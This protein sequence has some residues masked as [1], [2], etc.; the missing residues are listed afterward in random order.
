MAERRTT[1]GTVVVAITVVAF[2][3]VVAF[4]PSARLDAAGDAPD[5]ECVQCHV[6]TFDQG[7]AHRV[8]HTPFFERQC[9]AC[10]VPEG[11]VVYPQGRVAPVSPITGSLVSQEAMWAKRQVMVSAASRATDHRIIFDDLEPDATY[12]FRV[13]VSD[14]AWRDARGGA[15]SQ[16]LGLRLAEVPDGDANSLVIPLPGIA[17]AGEVS[18]A[19]TLSR[20]GESTLLIR[21]QTDRPLFGWLELETME[22]IFPQGGAGSE[23]VATAET[24]PPLR[25]PEEAAIDVCYSCHPAPSIG[26]SHPVRVYAQGGEIR[27]PDDLPTV[28]DGMITC[29]TCHD[30]H[31]ADGKHLVRETIKTKLCVACHYRFRGTSTATMF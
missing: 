27:I 25:D 14:Q 10:H 23:P 12:R 15:A 30:P 22:S 6:A 17:A 26:T 16:W 24:H 29:V 2:G 20:L 4:V 9:S 7:L 19:A 8:I 3:T 31:G 18:G 11:A 13:V 28:R 1:R 5:D 21:W